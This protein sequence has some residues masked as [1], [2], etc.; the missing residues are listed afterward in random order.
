MPPDPEPVISRKFDPSPPE[1]TPAPSRKFDPDPPEGESAPPKPSG[2]DPAP[3]TAKSAP[4]SKQKAS[5]PEPSAPA[6]PAAPAIPPEP[7]LSLSAAFLVALG[8]NV[9][10]ALGIFSL[11]AQWGPYE[12]IAA[13]QFRFLA[14][15]YP[16]LTFI[17]TLVICGFPA[18][19]LR[20]L[21]SGGGRLARILTYVPAG[22]ALAAHLGATLYFL[23]TAASP[24]ENTSIA[25]AAHD[26][27]FLPHQVRLTPDNILLLNQRL[28]GD[29]AAAPPESGGDPQRQQL[30]LPFYP[31]QWPDEKTPVFLSLK[32]A[33]LESHRE[34]P[35]EI[36]GTIR[37]RPLPYLA[38]RSAPP[39]TPLFSTVLTEYESVR[40]PWIV[41]AVIY[42]F[43]AIYLARR[44]WLARRIPKFSPPR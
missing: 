23:I 12:W 39:S 26:A 38:R 30:Y 42:A 6:P 35:T 27:T 18:L 29:L 20:G 31:S 36:V 4:A 32:K 19:L 44:F 8:F 34:S 22:L 13:L 28:M 25:T 3:G 24:P 16:A 10:V 17:L 33:S 5:G 14:R 1:P 2:A 7:P 40:A 41:A 21:A 15:E 43:L 9:I 11:W 37:I